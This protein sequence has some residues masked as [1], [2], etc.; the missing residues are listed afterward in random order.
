MF[1]GR[2]ELD[3]R[4]APTS[5]SLSTCVAAPPSVL[6]GVLAD[7]VN[8]PRLDGSRMIR[9]VDEAGPISSVG[10]TFSMR[11]RQVVPYRA[12][13]TVIDFRPGSAIAWQTWSQ[14]AGRRVMG[15]QVWSYALEPVAPGIT[16]VVQTYDWSDARH[17]W[18]IRV[19]GYP[20][21]MGAAMAETLHR[22]ATVATSEP[23]G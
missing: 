16:E 6:F 4:P 2:A 12:V 22:L 21:R 7:P 5:I 23:E 19:G 8:H 1:E 13:N 10:D 18:V 9:G 14:V 15:G 11:M 3:Q 20:E 17:A